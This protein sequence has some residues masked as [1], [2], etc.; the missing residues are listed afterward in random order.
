MTSKNEPLSSFDLDLSFGKEGEDF[1][2]ELLTGGRTVEVKRDRKWKET[3]NLYIE[4]ACYFVGK[5]AW[6]PS[7]LSVTKASYWAFVIED[8]VL[9][10]PT[11]ALKYCAETYGRFI[12]C[13]IQP[14]PSKGV[15]ITVPQILKAIKEYKT[16]VKP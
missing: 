15:L 3:G 1:V 11:D 14:N 2:K 12:D 8:A 9:L 7:G 6:G 5:R 10:V 13:N 16:G 4:T